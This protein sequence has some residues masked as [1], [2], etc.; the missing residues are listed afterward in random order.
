MADAKSTNEL[1]ATVGNENGGVQSGHSAFTGEE[2]VSRSKDIVSN[3]GYCSVEM[4]GYTVASFLVCL[5]NFYN[6]SNVII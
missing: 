6:N 2:I 5:S 1:E 3:L 4:S